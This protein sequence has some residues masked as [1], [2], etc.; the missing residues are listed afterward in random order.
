M[1]K[2]TTSDLKPGDAIVF[3]NK[4][5]LDN[6]TTSTPIEE[7]YDDADYEDHIAMF[8]HFDEAG[9]PVVIH[10]IQGDT[11]SKPSGLIESTLQKVLN[12]IDTFSTINNETGEKKTITRRYDVEFQVFRYQDKS[13]AKEALTFLKLWHDYDIPYDTARLN[14]KLKLED[15][16]E[17][18]AEDFYRLAKKRYE[19]EGKFRAL[20]YAVRRAESLTQSSL[21]GK[22]HGLT[23]SMSF[24]LAFQVAE[25]DKYVSTL[26]EV[27][28]QL[29]IG[30]TK[31]YNSDKHAVF[32]PNH[33]P[34]IYVNYLEAIKNENKLKQK[35]YVT[36]LQFCRPGF[37]IYT[38]NH[39]SFPID[40]K[41]I[42]VAGI[43]YLFNQS[44]NWQQIGVLDL[45]GTRPFTKEAVEAYRKKREIVQRR[46]EAKRYLFAL[47]GHFG[48]YLGENQAKFA[49][50][51]RVVKANVT[52]VK[53]T[54]TTPEK[55]SVPMP[56]P[57]NSDPHHHYR[58][59][60]RLPLKAANNAK[61]NVARALF[62]SSIEDK[63]AQEV[64]PPFQLEI[65]R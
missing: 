33:L 18:G 31:L 22:G 47:Q 58:S 9:N 40:A 46:K 26:T 49:E 44:P 13:L 27:N 1:P 60:S 16:E 50:S 19:T 56:T 10:S 38:F 45:G 20:K 42:G 25:L 51:L 43:V 11:P 4:Y 53:S 23:C 34:P 37:D 12:K 29:K 7:R 32:N 36:S 61:P 48:S 55:P 52:E 5:Y 57:P 39:Q 17:Y 24:V 2:I 15:E 63:I 8:S 65:K 6:A 59:L 3:I 28:S 21:H 35:Y 14:E 41:C 62:F 30:E 54:P 64:S